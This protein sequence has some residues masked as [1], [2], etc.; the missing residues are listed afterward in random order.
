MQRN[1]TAKGRWSSVR[2]KSA[3]ITRVDHIRGRGKNKTERWRK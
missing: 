1:E 2:E 3:F